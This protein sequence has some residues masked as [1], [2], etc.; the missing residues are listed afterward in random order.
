MLHN[1]QFSSLLLKWNCDFN[2]RD[3]PWKGVKDPYKIW[4]SEIILQQTRVEQGE[5]YY[6]SLLAKY[7]TVNDLANANPENVYMLWQGL[8]YYN[9]CRNMLESARY[10]QSEFNN[11][12]PNVYA[13]IIKL[14]GVG[15]YTAAAIASFAYNL[16][17]AVV[18][19]NVVRVISRVFGLERSFYDSAGKKYY[20]ELAQNLLDKKK[21]AAY[22]QAIMDFGA[23]ICKPKLPECNRCPF[24][25]HCVAKNEN[26]IENLPVKKVKQPLRIRHFHFFVFEDKAHLYIV[27]R[28]SKDIW[29][30]LFT[31]YMMESESEIVHSYDP[32]IVKSIQ[33]DPQV[34][35][36]ILS[37][38][39]IYGYFHVVKKINKDGIAHLNL[40]E[41]NKYD[42]SSYAFP[43][44]L[45]SFLEKNNYL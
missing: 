32:I 27:K 6:N 5:K 28:T 26:R 12:F 9:R 22:N 36:Q 44:L 45:I 42:L 29:N 21:S 11:I 24:E 31:F 37:H 15:D 25:K 1:Q 38:Q 2:R 7:P 33:K 41:I 34:F 40:L 13:D 10:I 19:G 20:Q 4:L 30:Q 23:T 8:G 18:D 16:P 39:K 43:R 3:M 35:Q 14:K 17:H